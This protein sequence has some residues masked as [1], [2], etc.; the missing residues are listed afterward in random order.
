M[1]RAKATVTKPKVEV[2]VEPKVEVKVEP[3]VE[4]KPTP[5]KKVIKRQGPFINGSRDIAFDEAVRWATDNN[6]SNPQ[7]SVGHNRDSND[8]EAWVT[9]ETTE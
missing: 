8:H 4:V 2:K 6:V 9:Y 5:K 3:K 7:L 1:A